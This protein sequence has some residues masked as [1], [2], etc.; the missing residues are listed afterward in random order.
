M[1]NWANVAEF[2]KVKN[3]EGGLV[4][5]ARAG[6]PFLLD[7]GMGVNVVPPV[8]RLPRRIHVSKVVEQGDGRFV[9]YFDEIPSIDEAEK[10]VGHFA[11]VSC[12]DLPD[13]WDAGEWAIAGFEVRLADGSLVGTIADVIENPAHPLL[14]VRRENR[15]DALI[16]LVDEF[17]VSVDGTDAVLVMNLPKGLLDL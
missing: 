4:V 15:D 12:D 17:I 9:V 7:E 14:V 5:R 3:L 11:L 8:L 1:G 10:L 16:P 2:T 6:L 13:G